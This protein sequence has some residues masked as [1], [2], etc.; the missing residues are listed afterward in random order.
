MIQRKIGFLFSGEQNVVLNNLTYVNGACQSI[1][2]GGKDFT[3]WD[4]LRKRT[5]LWGGVI[6]EVQSSHLLSIVKVPDV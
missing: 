5:F 2:L 6:K 3:R 1:I 4:R